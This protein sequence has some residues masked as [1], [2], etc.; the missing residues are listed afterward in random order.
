MAESK[1]VGL[2]SEIEEIEGMKNQNISSLPTSS[3]GKRSHEDLN[4]STDV[5]A[6]VAKKVKTTAATNKKKL[7]ETE[8][9]I[10]SKL[11]TA[12]EGELRAYLKELLTT[13][14]ELL[15]DSFEAFT[16]KKSIQPA[17]DDPLMTSC[18]MCRS[19]DN[20]SPIAECKICHNCS[21]D[22]LGKY[23]NL[24]KQKVTSYFY[25]ID[26]EAKAIPFYATR[27]GFHTVYVYSL[28][29]VLAAVKKKYGSFYLMAKEKYPKRS[30]NF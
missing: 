30:S 27:S 8:K 29:D 13:H 23:G 4:P 26:A 5:I 21:E 17:V 18:F 28:A 20:L 11:K 10:D 15:K 9:E 6:P 7:K 24:T 2:G 12:M 1:N 19:R 25:F 22:M 16:P 3:S 14:Y